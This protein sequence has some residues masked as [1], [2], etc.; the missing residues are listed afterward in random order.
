LAQAKYGVGASNFG[1]T[2]AIVGD[3]YA[4][5]GWPLIG[6][7]FSPVGPAR[8]IEGTGYVAVSPLRKG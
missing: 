8:W 6:V 5:Q 4:F 2:L 1:P 3:G 7:V